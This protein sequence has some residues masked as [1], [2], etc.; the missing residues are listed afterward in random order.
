MKRDSIE[1]LHEIYYGGRDPDDVDHK[2]LHKALMN[3]LSDEGNYLDSYSDNGVH[4]VSA[5]NLDLPKFLGKKYRNVHFSLSPQ[6]RSMGYYEQMKEKL[7]YLP[8]LSRRH[9]IINISLPR[10]NSIKDDEELLDNHEDILKHLRSNKV[11]DTISH[12]IKHFNDFRGIRGEFR[13]REAIKSDLDYFNKEHEFR[14][15][16]KNMK[17]GIERS[18][19]QNGNSRIKGDISDKVLRDRLRLYD[20]NS[21]RDRLHVISSHGTFELGPHEWY[22]KLSDENKAH[23]ERL[24]QPIIDKYRKQDISNDIRSKDP[25]IRSRGISDN[26]SSQEHIEQGLRDEHPMVKQ[27]AMR[28]VDK[29]GYR[30]KAH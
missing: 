29:R 11:R 30:I 6:D 23:A 19:I 5:K 10:D 13:K 20:N 16:T 2:V 4:Y 24:I 25:V 26:K 14:A 21:F 3:Y 28:E 15:W 18:L 7:K 1:E 12:E 22:D 8:F 9:H 17:E 27:A